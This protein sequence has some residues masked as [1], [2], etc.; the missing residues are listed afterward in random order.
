M[1][2]IAFKQKATLLMMSNVTIYREDHFSVFQC[3]RARAVSE[4]KDVKTERRGHRINNVKWYNAL[5]LVLCAPL[6]TI[7]MVH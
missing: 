2:E 6:S 7:V 1:N 5:S 3:V 4:K